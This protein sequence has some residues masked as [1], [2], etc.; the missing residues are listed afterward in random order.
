VFLVFEEEIHVEKLLSQCHT[1]DGHHYL[2]L[3]S[4]TVRDKPVGVLWCT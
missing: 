4:Q 2:L 3:S 1:E